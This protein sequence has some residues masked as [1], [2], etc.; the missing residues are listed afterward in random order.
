MAKRP[1]HLEQ[2][3]NLK[4]CNLICRVQVSEC[5]QCVTRSKESKNPAGD[6]SLDFASW[7]VVQTRC[8]DRA[9]EGGFCK[10]LPTWPPGLL[11]LKQLSEHA[12]SR[13]AK[14][15]P[16]LAFGL[17]VDEKVGS[18]HF[19]CRLCK[20][21]TTMV[22]VFR[23][24]IEPKLKEGGIGAANGLQLCFGDN[25]SARFSLI[26]GACFAFRVFFLP[27]FWVLFCVPLVLLFG[28]KY[29]IV[30]ALQDCVAGPLALCD[31]GDPGWGDPWF[32]H[33]AVLLH[34]HDGMATWL[35][36]LCVLSFHVFAIPIP[37]LI[38]C[39]HLI[40]SLVTELDRRSLSALRFWW[41]FF[42]WFWFCVFCCFGCCLF[43]C[44]VFKWNHDGCWTMYR[45]HT[46]SL[47]W[48]P[49][50]WRLSVCI[51]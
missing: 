39:Y 3:A 45:S 37:E 28:F 17:Q 30:T 8:A 51:N 10:L 12:Y 38:Q 26:K 41:V 29:C 23:C 4:E 27:V 2:F 40:S 44:C 43:V 49:T 32:P 9:W 14:L 19:L 36:C 48:P 20:G 31:L 46:S 33:S 24:G 11:L 5:L 21:G 7:R 22:C 25:D 35:L 16:E 13:S 50:R 34:S 18:W 15:S 42:V 6:D 47:L 1:Q